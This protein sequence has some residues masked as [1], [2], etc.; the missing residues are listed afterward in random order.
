MDTTTQAVR[1]LLHEAGEVHHSVFRIVDGVDDDWASWYADWLV[2]LSELPELLATEPVRSE[3]V[4]VLVSL[5]KRYTADA[6]DEDWEPYYAR[7]IVDHFGPA[8]D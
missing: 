2:R 7:G 3:L 4:Y 5:D 6:P 1:E 8:A